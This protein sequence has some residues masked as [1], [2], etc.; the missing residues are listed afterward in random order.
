MGR[1]ERQGNVV[2]G[3]NLPR[4]FRAI[5]PLTKIDI[6]QDQIGVSACGEVRDGVLAG[7]YVLYHVTLL[8]ENHLLVQGD[9]RL[10]FNKENC[11]IFWH[12]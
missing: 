12:N 6:H 4:R 2:A 10:I 1:K 11:F 7:G 9:D 3:Q 8:P 5:D